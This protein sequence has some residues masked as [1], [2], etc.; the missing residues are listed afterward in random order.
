VRACVVDVV[1][2]TRL[3]SRDGVVGLQLAVRFTATGAR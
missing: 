2:H 1:R 3:P